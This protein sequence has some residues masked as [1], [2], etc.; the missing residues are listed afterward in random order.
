M[1]RKDIEKR[2]VKNFMM[3]TRKRGVKRQA[4]LANIA[5][6]PVEERPEAFG[7]FNEVKGL[8]DERIAVYK[9]DVNKRVNIGLRGTANIEDIGTDITAVIGGRRASNPYFQQAQSVLDKVRADNP[10]YRITV[11]GHSLGGSVSR[12]LARNNPD[13][14]AF[15]YNPGAFIGDKFRTNP[16]NFF[17]FRNKTDVVSM[18]D[19]PSNIGG[20]FFD[21]PNPLRA[22]SIT[23]F[24]SRD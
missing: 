22:H 2:S 23:T 15:G 17:T 20:D 5:Y 9:D 8:S 4:E 12:E 14:K 13:I 18:L 7:T 11:S 10:E 6:A 3:G 16:E 19:N 24:T 21:V 1:F